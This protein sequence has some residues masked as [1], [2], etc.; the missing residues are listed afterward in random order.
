MFFRVSK[1]TQCPFCEQE[2]I[3]PATEQEKQQIMQ[4]L[5][6]NNSEN[7]KKER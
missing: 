6:N 3:R 4:Q 5:K 1:V 2:H 7:I